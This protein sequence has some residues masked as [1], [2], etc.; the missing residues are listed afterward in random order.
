MLFI[1]EGDWYFEAFFWKASK[2][3][4][5][6]PV[7]P[8]QKKKIKIRIHSLIINLCHITKHVRGAK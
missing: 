7:N 6:N 5:N 8:V 2:K 4:P 1:A 3:Y